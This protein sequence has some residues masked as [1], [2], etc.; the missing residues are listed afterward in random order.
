VLR[1]RP[2]NSVLGALFLQRRRC[3][4]WHPVCRM[5]F[6]SAFSVPHSCSAL[7]VWFPPD[8]A[9]TRFQ[10]AQI[11]L[12]AEA[13]YVDALD[14]VFGLFAL[15]RSLNRLPELKAVLKHLS[16]L[17]GVQQICAGRPVTF[18]RTCSGFIKANVAVWRKVF[19]RLQLRKRLASLSASVFIADCPFRQKS[20]LAGVVCC[21]ALLL[22]TR[23]LAETYRRLHTSTR[24]GRLELQTKSFSTSDHKREINCRARYVVLNHNVVKQN[25]QRIAKIQLRKLKLWQSANWC[26]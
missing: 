22:R 2:K 23:W 4:Q 7:H 17:A 21:R 15:G 9:D 14:P 5:R 16:C 12:G 10:V 24:L 25:C 1:T 6:K 20:C 13:E 19:G 18:C 11:G 8:Y 26:F 3:R